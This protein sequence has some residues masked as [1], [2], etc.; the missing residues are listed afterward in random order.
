M[1][2]FFLSHT[3]LIFTAMAVAACLGVD[4]ANPSTADAG[5][6]DG[7]RRAAKLIPAK[8]S[9]SPGDQTRIAFRSLS[10]R[11]IEFGLGFTVE[12]RIEGRWVNVN[13]ELCGDRGCV[14]PD[15]GLIAKPGQEVG[16]KYGSL[17]DG[18]Y[19]PADA[20]T[21]RY[22]ISKE[23]RLGRDSV[24]TRTILRV[25]T[26]RLLLSDTDLEV[27]DSVRF[28]VRNTGSLPLGYGFPVEV[29]RRQGD[30]WV[31]AQD[32]ICPGGCNF[33]LPELLV[34]PG[35]IRGP[36]FGKNI[37]AIRFKSSAPAGSYRVKKTIGFSNG[38]V[39]RKISAQLT[40]A[41]SP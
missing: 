30:S 5:E 3:M 2:R 24:V 10:R 7:H 35:Q 9:V 39:D 19:F 32:A 31:D 25:G 34:E 40:L 33:I 23:F 37:D 29:E 17:V 28:R 22:R 20:P 21:G 6:G 8:R 15:V 12:R 1:K 18:V 41:A 13:A 36:V 4:L 38:K 27:G 11:P 26:A 14:T 16:P